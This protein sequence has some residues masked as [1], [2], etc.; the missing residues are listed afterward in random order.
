MHCSKEGLCAHCLHGTEHM[1]YHL[2]TRW[3]R[4]PLFAIVF[5]ELVTLLPTPEDW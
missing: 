2:L 5:P 3:K 1:F 4:V